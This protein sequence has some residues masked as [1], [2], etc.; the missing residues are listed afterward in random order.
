MAEHENDR[1]TRADLAEA[2]ARITQAIT[3]SVLQIVL[4]VAAI[5]AVMV[6]TVAMLAL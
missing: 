1:V 5:T 2:E 4:A 6:L 3:R